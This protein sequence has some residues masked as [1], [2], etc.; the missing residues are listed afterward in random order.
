MKKGVLKH[1]KSVG[2]G[3][4]LGSDTE[5]AEKL[6]K[7]TYDLV[8]LKENHKGGVTRPTTQDFF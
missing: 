4:G 2:R 8:S 3:L 6:G 5:Q 7:F 1:K